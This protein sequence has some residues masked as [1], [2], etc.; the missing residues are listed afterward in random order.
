M[1]KIEQTA[2]ECGASHY[3]E[4][5]RDDEIVINKGVTIF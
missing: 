3:A 1:K 2:V 4:V 5:Y